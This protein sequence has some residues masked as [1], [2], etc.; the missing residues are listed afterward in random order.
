[1]GVGF[2]G[3]LPLSPT[4]ELVMKIQMIAQISGSR[5]GIDWPAPGGIL[6]VPADEAAD[7]IKSKIARDAKDAPKGSLI[8]TAV[9][10]KAETRKRGTRKTPAPAPA[11]APAGL[12]KESLGA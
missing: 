8:E 7:L 4:L 1:M 11:P 10:P 5:E 12:T 2:F 9:A 3:A 6:D